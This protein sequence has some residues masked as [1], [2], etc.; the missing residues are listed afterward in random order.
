MMV[1]LALNVGEIQRH[2][3]SQEHGETR[4]ASPLMRLQLDKTSSCGQLGGI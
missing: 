2:P 3:L 1:H 4:L